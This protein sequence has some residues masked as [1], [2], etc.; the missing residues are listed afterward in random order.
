MSKRLVIFDLDGTL[1][2]TIGDLARACNFVMRTHGWPEHDEAQYRMMVGNGI[3]KLIERALPEH[4]RSAE[5]AERLRPEFIAYYNGHIDERTVP[6]CGIPELLG[7]LSRRGVMMAVASNKY[8]EGT[9]KL[10]GK[11]FA[12]IPFVAVLGQRAGIPVKP[13]P[14]IVNEIMQK[15]G[16]SLSDTLYVG[17]SGVDMLTAANAG[18]ESVGVLWGFRHREELEQ[19]KACHIVDTAGK[20]SDLV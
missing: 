17:D 9:Q 12:D 2:D 1:L 13:D 19:N 6:Y 8:M 20:I 4:V 11:F 15:A 7:S 16:V 5:T 10:I 3:N 18:V 14:T